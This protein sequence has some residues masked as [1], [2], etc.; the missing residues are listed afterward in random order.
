MFTVSSW[1]RSS[2][3]PR[4]V[5]A[6]L[7]AWVGGCSI[8]NG[9]RRR[10]VLR[11]TQIYP[12]EDGEWKVAHRHGDT[13]ESALRL[14]A[15]KAEASPGWHARFTVAKRREGAKPRLGAVAP[16]DLEVERRSVRRPRQ[17]RPVEQ[18]GRTVDA[19]ARSRGGRNS[20][21]ECADD[22]RAGAGPA[23]AEEDRRPGSVE[24]QLQ[25]PERERTPTPGI[26]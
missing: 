23:G 12:R 4:C 1:R 19:R 2:T 5:S 18:P 25:P 24:P 17:V 16:P 20:R 22:N 7:S 8:I 3:L 6:R 14:I 21:Q 10:Y 26:R 13:A 15:T 9:E 11:V